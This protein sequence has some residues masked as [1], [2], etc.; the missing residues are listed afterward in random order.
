MIAPAINAA[1]ARG[2]IPDADYIRV[3]ERAKCGSSVTLAARNDETLCRSS[4]FNCAMYRAIMNATN[5][6]AR[7]R[8]VAKSLRAA[9]GIFIRAD[10][11]G[12][13][14]LNGA[15]GCRRTVSTCSLP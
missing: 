9:I 11:G 13:G 8:A 3:R 5:L 4:N 10:R 14:W 12:R 1:R 15:G 7:H 2:G 6:A